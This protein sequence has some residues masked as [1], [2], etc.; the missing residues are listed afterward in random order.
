MNTLRQGTIQTLAFG[1]EGILRDENQVIFVPFTAPGDMC[2]VELVSKKKNFA[3]GRL[4]TLITPSPH[5]VQPQCPYFGTC[6]GCQLQHLAYPVQIQSKKIFI[7]D[8]LQRIGKI[9]FPEIQMTPASLQWSYRKHIRLK[10]KPTEK[11]FVAGYTAYDKMALLPVEQCPIF[12]PHDDPLF[13]TVQPLLSALSN[14]GIEEGFLKLIKIQTNQYILAFHFP[15]VLP[16]NHSI[17]GSYLKQHNAWQGIVMHSPQ[18]QKHWGRVDCEIELCGLKARFSPLGFV[19]NHPE[20]SE[21][22]YQTIMQA[23]PA[24]ANKILDLY[25]GIGLTSL[26]FSQLGKEVVGI[27]SHSETIQL[28]KENAKA[29]GLFPQFKEGKAEILGAELLKNQYFDTVLCNPPRTGLDSQL[30]QV[31]LQKQPP[32][33]LYVSCMPAT[34]ARDLHHLAQGGYRVDLVHGIDMFPQTTHVETVVRCQFEK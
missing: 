3:Q 4:R 18:Q 17:C 12:L 28:A 22:L 7:H 16:E 11:G 30:I 20:Q 24:T 9:P 15:S 23:L 31:L 6:G 13:L 14:Q 25:C 19:Q 32:C 34:L 10:L 26:L 33:I 5:R 2:T 21:I 29:N 1:G 8:A 27:E